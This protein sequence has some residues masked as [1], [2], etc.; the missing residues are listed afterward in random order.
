[1]LQ[2]KCG[3]RHLYKIV[4]L[5][6]SDKHQDMEQLNH[7]FVE[8]LSCFLK[9]ML[10]LKFIVLLGLQTLACF[11]HVLL[12]LLSKFTLA[13]ALMTT[14]SSRPQSGGLVRETLG[15]FQCLQDSQ[16]NRWGEAFPEPY[17]W[18]SWWSPQHS[19][20]ELSPFNALW[21]SYMSLCQSPPYP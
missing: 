4:I 5:F 11:L 9:V 2:W 7:I 19:H 15:H 12:N 8:S 18:A 1:M 3:C 13:A 21:E 20:Q 10:Q 16:G 6:F 14:H 17:G